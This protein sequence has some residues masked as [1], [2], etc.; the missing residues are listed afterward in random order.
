[1]RRDRSRPGHAK[2]RSCPYRSWTSDAADR[3][4]DHDALV[5][6]AS[7]VGVSVEAWTAIG[8]IAAVLAVLV[9]GFAMRR[10]TGPSA[11]A[12]DHATVSDAAVPLELGLSWMAI[13]YADGTV[14]DFGIGLSLT[15]RQPFAVQWV[16]AHLDLQ[17]GSGRH[18]Q[19]IATAPPPLTVPK[20][21]QPQTTESVW[22]SEE[23]VTRS[24]IDLT[25]PMT[26]S[27]TIGTGEMVRSQPWTADHPK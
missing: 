18:A 3:C 5:I 4:D 6:G 25:R 24:G 17:D 20:W 13:T 8:A 26:G 23:A 11:A 12:H 16:S 19:L 27:A 14:G 15:N 2:A 10:S 22:V 1:M 21:V 7:F 9:S